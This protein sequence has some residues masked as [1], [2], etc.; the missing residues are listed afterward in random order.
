LRA[1]RVSS[2]AG[3][4]VLLRGVFAPSFNFDLAKEG[5]LR[6]LRNMQ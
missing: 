2:C 4:A 1:A 6:L 5:R 3:V